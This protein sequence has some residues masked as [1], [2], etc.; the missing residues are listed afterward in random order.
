MGHEPSTRLTAGYL[1]K[2]RSLSF[3]CNQAPPKVP[4]RESYEVAR[5]S[6]SSPAIAVECFVSKATGE[7]LGLDCRRLA[8]KFGSTCPGDLDRLLA[9][10]NRIALGHSVQ[11]L[12]EH[13][14]QRL[15]HLLRDRKAPPAVPGILQPENA[16]DV[17]RELQQL[18]RS[19]Y[20]QYRAQTGVAPQMN[21]TEP[22][23]PDAPTVWE[24]ATR[25]A[26]VA[27]AT[28][29][30]QAVVEAAAL[31][32]PL[33][34]IVE[35]KGKHKLFL[36]LTK[37]VSAAR[38]ARLLSAIE[39]DLREHLDPRLEVF[40]KSAADRNV[41]RSRQNAVTLDSDEAKG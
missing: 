33:V 36:A 29:R 9:V 20:A 7:V 38:A 16:S 35:I 12:S 18:V 37:A 40:L 2:L 15:E 14:V 21:R 8:T 32:T 41:K 5:L 30:I 4:L 23:P 34:E 25:D 6:A 31:A 11:D 1:R 17:F 22:P 19:V 26:R 27:A 13:G 24:R 10:F 39:D 3:P 28:A